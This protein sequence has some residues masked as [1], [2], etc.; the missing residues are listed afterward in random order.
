MKHKQ[1]AAARGAPPAAP[2][3]S[4]QQGAEPAAAEDGRETQ[5]REAAYFRYL[6]RGAVVGHEMED[7]L[8]AEAALLATGQADDTNH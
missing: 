3:K 8:Q 4:T 1:P 5:I 2:V 6:A 7:W